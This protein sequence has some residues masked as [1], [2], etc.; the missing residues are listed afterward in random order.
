MNFQE[1]KQDKVRTVMGEF[2]A[3]KLKLRGNRK[4]TDRRQAIAIALNEAERK[5]KIN[6]EDIK[7]LSSRVSIFLKEDSKKINES[8]LDLSNVIETRRYIEHLVSSKQSTKALK[9]EHRL[10]KRI[11]DAARNNINITPNIWNELHKIQTKLH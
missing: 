1:C 2:K 3:G 4:V 7:D 8:K 11:T 6:R 9:E 5:C 10:V